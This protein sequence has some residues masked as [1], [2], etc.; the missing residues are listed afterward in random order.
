MSSCG[1][2]LIRITVLPAHPLQ[3][4]TEFYLHIPSTGLAKLAEASEQPIEET[5]QCTGLTW[6]YQPF[7][8]EWQ[9]GHHPRPMEEPLPN[10]PAYR[11][12][13]GDATTAVPSRPPAASSPDGASGKLKGFVFFNPFNG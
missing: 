2:E 11:S 7:G 5:I 12:L 9:K 10:V 8:F 6:N 13:A 4:S 3:K 1:S